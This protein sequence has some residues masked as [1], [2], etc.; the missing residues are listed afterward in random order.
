[1]VNKPRRLWMVSG[2]LIAL[3][4]LGP[5]VMLR[6]NETH[7]QTPQ[8]YDGG[9]LVSG[10]HT[11]FAS[12]VSSSDA[13][14]AS[15]L[16]QTGVFTD[17][18]AINLDGVAAVMDGNNIVFS[19]LRIDSQTTSLDD[20][21]RISFVF[22]SSNLQLMP[23]KVEVVSD[24]GL[25][26]PEEQLFL[27][28]VTT[29]L[30][31]LDPEGES[32]APQTT[33]RMTVG[34]DDVLRLNMESGTLLTMRVNG[35]NDDF[36]LQVRDP[37]GNYILNPIFRAGTSWT[38]FNRPILN[39]GVHTIRFIPRNNETVTLNVGV[40]N[41]NQSTTTE[42][43]SGDS[44]SASLSD[45]GK[46]YEK[47]RI[48]L[49]RG[50]IVRMSAAGAGVWLK[51]IDSNGALLS[52]VTGGE[53]NQRIDATGTYY[54]IVENDGFDRRRSYSG[55][56]TVEDDE[57]ADQY[58]SL[59][60]IPAAQQ[61]AQVGQRFTLQLSATNMNTLAS[62]AASSI[63]SVTGLPPGLEVN[64]QTGTITGTPTEPGV[65]PIRAVASNSYGR[66]RTDFL[67]TIEGG[68]GAPTLSFDTFLP[69]I[70]RD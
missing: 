61:Q 17:I 38:I 22:N 2:L 56:V 5:A 33:H 10:K 64:E 32:L 36:N 34:A 11:P 44:I 14:L 39:S 63:Y 66:D 47:Y 43:R 27:K 1:M 68:D 65:F 60:E 15:M 59:A 50:Q 8:S 3:L 13:M 51:I 35:A 37:D 20:F 28:D 25:Y 67:L 7:A 31:L 48:E 53:L 55:T 12:G 18:Q 19:N 16:A 9:A 41:N 29:E 52:D 49:E 62:D 45:W 58:P 70:V 23:T 4:M 57:F 30:D 21:L 40:H 46:D 26:L 6:M 69:V 24:L 42:V 54:L